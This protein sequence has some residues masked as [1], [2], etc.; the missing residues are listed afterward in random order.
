MDIRK[1]SKF[2]TGLIVVILIV[3][4]CFCLVVNTL[5]WLNEIYEYTDDNSNIGK[6][7]VCLYA[8][9]VK[10]GSVSKV[11]ETWT[12]SQPYQLASGST[13]RNVGL[14]VRNEGNIDALVRVTINVYYMENNNKRTAL[15]TSS[16]PT[17]GTIQLNAGGWTTQFPDEDV[18]CGYMYYSTQ[19]Q[20]YN[21]KIVDDGVITSGTNAN[22]ESLIIT[23]IVVS[24]AQKNTIFYV[25]ISVDA[26]A[27][28]GNIYKKLEANETS[29]SDI[30]VY[31]YPFG[32][33]ENLPTNW[34]A[35]K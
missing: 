3:T 26:V 24:E 13:T 17:Q 5:A 32:K 8:D 28:A 31:A 20:S 22:G 7:D 15:I 25:D 16:T 34:E 1:E 35:W 11:G 6:I 21:T 9:G 19:L 23:S 14:K 12:N 33:K 4:L 29:A 18:A 2:N 27:Y 10:R 30:P